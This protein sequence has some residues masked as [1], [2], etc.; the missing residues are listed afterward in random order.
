MSFREVE[1]S[2]V[3]ESAIRALRK[4]ELNITELIDTIS[5]ELGVTNGHANYLIS[6]VYKRDDGRN[7]TREN[8]NGVFVYSL[9]E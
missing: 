7:M 1:I 6:E 5:S 3:F 2:A 8:K 4:G 9:I